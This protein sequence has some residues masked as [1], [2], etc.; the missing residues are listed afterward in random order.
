[1]TYKVPGLF[2]LDPIEADV[3]E[4]TLDKGT[5]PE[6]IIAISNHNRTSIFQKEG[7]TI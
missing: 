3:S 4:L 6:I 7:L 2:P 5:L 1:M